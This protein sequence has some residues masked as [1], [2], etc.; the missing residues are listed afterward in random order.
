MS[1][2]ANMSV[3]QMYLCVITRIVFLAVLRPILHI[4]LNS[5]MLKEL[6]S[7]NFTLYKL[8]NET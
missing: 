7:L 3:E 2:L 5:S 4:L 8:V 6:L 1:L